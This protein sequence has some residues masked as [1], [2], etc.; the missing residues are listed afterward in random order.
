ML[1]TIFNDIGTIDQ[2]GDFRR[3][4]LTTLRD[5]L[6]ANELP[7]E[8]E[9]YCRFESKVAVGQ[10]ITLD[11]LDDLR[12]ARGKEDCGTAACAVGWAPL[13]IEPDEEFLAG[14]K[15]KDRFSYNHYSEKYLLPTDNDWW[16]W[17]FSGGWS[18]VDNSRLG[19]A[20]RISVLL[21]ADDTDLRAGPPLTEYSISEEEADDVS[22][23]ENRAKWLAERGIKE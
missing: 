18:S 11:L 19:A 15:N 5:A 7:F 20:Y 8:M 9:T 6:L 22:Y 1:E 21:E 3:K 13:F 23:F 2:L 4:N 14:Y 17:C 10:V 16:D 12:K